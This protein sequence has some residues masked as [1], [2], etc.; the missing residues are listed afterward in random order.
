MNWMIVRVAVSEHFRSGL[1]EVR[2]GWAFRDLIQ[3]HV[4]LDELERMAD[5]AK[6]EAEANQGAG[7]R[8]D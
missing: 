6:R 1:T 7:R 5:D 2:C 4:V 8:H 3:A